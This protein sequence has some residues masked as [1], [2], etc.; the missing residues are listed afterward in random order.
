[1]SK[2]TTYPKP[3]GMSIKALEKIL[4]REQNGECDKNWN[5][6]ATIRDN[7][8]KAVLETSTLSNELTHDIPPSNAYL[9][10]KQYPTKQTRLSINEPIGLPSSEI[11]IILFSSMI[12]QIF[13]M[14]I[15]F[16][17]ALIGF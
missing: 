1:M 12:P 6:W 9:L 3:K 8:R 4:I 14:G 17:I 15:I 7:C 13:M 11:I 2:P 10:E 16:Y 5:E